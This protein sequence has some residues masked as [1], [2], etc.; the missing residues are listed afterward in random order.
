MEKLRQHLQNAK[1]FCKPCRKSWS[2]LC[3]FFRVYAWDVEMIACMKY[4]GSRV[5]YLMEFLSNF[6]GST[7]EDHYME[8]EHLN[9]DPVWEAVEYKHKIIH[10]PSQIFCH[11]G[12][13]C[14]CKFVVQQ[15]EI[16]FL[17]VVYCCL[18]FYAIVDIEA[19]FMVKF[20]SSLEEWC[21]WLGEWCYS[22]YR[23]TIRGQISLQLGRVMSLPL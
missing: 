20:L 12:V 5:F 18:N 6:W 2:Q 22:W 3:N 16:K 21:H 11:V 19:Q 9:I 10:A 14:F 17:A 13:G 7:I 15:S 23:G 4:H 1:I 8:L